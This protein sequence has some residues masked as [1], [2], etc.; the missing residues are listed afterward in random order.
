MSEIYGRNPVV[1][2]IKS[3]TEI[4]RIY[5]AKGA[6]HKVIDDIY[7]LATNTRATGRTSQI[8]YDVSR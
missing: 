2:A 6:Q 3:G 8:G 1:E 4:N 5:I 7:K